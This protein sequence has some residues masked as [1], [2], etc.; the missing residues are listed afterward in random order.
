M[1]APGDL[2][3]RDAEPERPRRSRAIV[4]RILNLPEYEA[5]SLV[6][7]FVGVG[8][9]VDTLPF[10]ETALA[11][12][13]RVAVPWVDGRVLHLLIWRAPATWPRRRSV[14]WNR[15]PICE[16]TLRGR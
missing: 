13:K 10:I 4:E 9:E 15:R 5:A 12:G 3:R 7:A 16:P 8:T 1:A 14:C 6:S 11:R 2:A